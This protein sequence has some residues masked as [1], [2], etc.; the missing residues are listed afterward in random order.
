MRACRVAMDIALCPDGFNQQRGLGN[1]CRVQLS[2]G[3][4]GGMI[5]WEI[6]GNFHGFENYV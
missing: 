5:G 3:T 6:H 2:L 1:L 4:Q